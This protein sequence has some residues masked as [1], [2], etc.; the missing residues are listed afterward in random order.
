MPYTAEHACRINDPGKYK[1]FR[2]QAGK[3]DQPD[4][5]FGIRPDGKSEVQSYRFPVD[6]FKEAKARA[7]C[8]E[9][10]GRFEKSAKPEAAQLVPK[11][12][13]AVSISAEIAGDTG[14][15]R[16]FRK[17]L[18]SVGAYVKED[19]GYEFSVNRTDL[20]RWIDTFNEMKRNGVTV[21]MPDAHET[22]GEASH[23]LGYVEEMF[24]EGDDLIGIVKLIGEDAIATAARADVSISVP[25]ALVDGKGNRYEQPIEH[26]AFTPTPLIPGLDPFIPLAA[27]RRWREESVT[28]DWKVLEKGLGLKD[29]GDDNACEQITEAF[30]VRTKDM[31]TAQA[32][33]KATEAKLKGADASL[34]EVRAKIKLEPEK[35][36]PVTLDMARKTQATQLDM[37]VKA[38]KITP[39]VR[40]GLHAL[41][42]GDK[43]ERIQAS[44]ANG[45]HELFNNV[46]SLFEK[47]DPVKLGEQSGPQTLLELSRKEASADSL[48]NRAKDRAKMAVG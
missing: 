45:T 22:F 13:P 11:T 29:L 25:P 7:F 34:A 35:L 48:L 43:G 21:P 2:R 9:H 5:I 18:I 23:N 12:Q 10:N 1:R 16:R 37:L 38:S 15:Y 3:D 27:S 44:A 31:E 32:S 8:Q 46:I 4:M 26:V 6:R 20:Q 28:M 14:P 17:H 33:L 36:G 40:D 39:A 24:M 30:K 47:N 19:Q 42:I 41:F